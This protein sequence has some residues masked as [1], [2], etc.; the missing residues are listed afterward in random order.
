M[1]L[2]K[3][4]SVFFVGAVIFIVLHMAYGPISLT[5]GIMGGRNIIVIDAGHG[6]KDPGTI[7]VNQ[8][9]EKDINLDISKKLYKKLGSMG[10]KV[11][12]TRDRDEYVDNQ[13]RVELANRKNAKLFVSIHCNALENDN[14]TRGIQV[15]YYPNEKSKEKNLDNESL[16]KTTLDRISKVTGAKN[17][18][19]VARED[20]LVLNQ[21]NMPAI[22]V[23][24]GFLSNED[25]ASLLITDEYQNKIV[26]GIV[27]VLEDY[28]K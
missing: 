24:C 19:I 7:G 20:L 28:T 13:K 21:T 14:S 5:E 15:L 10:Y 23:E 2:K 8:S 12:L 17:R 18:G 25:E 3:R 27:D 22:I 11:I 1:K 6:G 16:A 26:D 4:R 9:F